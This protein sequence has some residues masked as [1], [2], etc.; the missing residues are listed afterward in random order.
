MEAVTRNPLADPSI[1]G[2]SSGAS[3]RRDRGHLFRFD[4]LLVSTSG[5]PSSAPSSPPCSFLMCCRLRQKRTHPG[6][7]ALA[8]IVISQCWRPG[9]APMLLLDRQT[10]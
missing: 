7:L 3:F 4:R 5:L 1:L 10:I 9:P 8:G 2:V 6:K